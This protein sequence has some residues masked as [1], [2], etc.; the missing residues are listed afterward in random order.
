M[1]NPITNNRI[2]SDK[3]FA[4]RLLAFSLESRVS[5]ACDED[6][7][8]SFISYS[9]KLLKY[10]LQTVSDKSEY[11]YL[12]RCKAKETLNKGLKFLGKKPF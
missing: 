4:L 11:D 5:N 1:D 8:E 7:I 9:T 12:I 6:E 2:G 3:T 10:Q